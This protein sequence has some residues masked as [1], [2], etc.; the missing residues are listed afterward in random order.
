MDEKIKLSKPEVVTNA[1]EGWN[2]EQ[3]TDDGA[4]LMAIFTG[5]HAEQ[6]A[7][8]YMALGAAGPYHLT[9]K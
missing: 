5:P 2:V 1:V 6:R 4:C 3:F 8:S 7:R 9:V